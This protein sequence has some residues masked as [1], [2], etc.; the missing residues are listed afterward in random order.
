[1][2]DTPPDRD[3]EWS[4]IGVQNVSKYLNKI[5]LFII[6]NKNYLSIHSSDVHMYGNNIDTGLI[7]DEVL[8]FRKA[9][10]RKLKKQPIV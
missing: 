5:W 1:M 7:T 2:S 9:M 10:H 8:S 3:M 4:D 6:E